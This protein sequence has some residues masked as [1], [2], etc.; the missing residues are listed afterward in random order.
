MEVVTIDFETYYSKEYSL[1]G[2]TTEEY[3]RDPRFEVIGVCIKV[4][5]NP[6]DWYSGSDPG[7]FLNS[8]SYKDKAIL[9][10]NTAFDGAILSWKYGIK[11]K[12]WLDTMS[13]ARPYHA[14][15]CGV[16]LAALAKEYGL[17]E[18]GTEIIAGLDK[19]RTDF[20]PEEL[21]RY[22][23]YC[24]R[25]TEITY[26]L[27]KKLAR[28]TTAAEI[29][30]ID[31][32]IRM[33]TEPAFDLDKDVLSTH[34]QQ[35]QDKKQKLLNA[36]TGGKVSD[37]EL[38]KQL[39]SNELFGSL[40]TKLGV[41]PPRKIS[42]T[43]G[44][45]TWAFSK[46]DKEFLALQEHPHKGVQALV[47]A[48]LGVKSTLEE[49]RTQKFIAVAERGRL[50]IL[51]NYWGAHTGRFSGGDGMNLQNLPR[52]GALRRAL[53]APPGK[54]VATCDSAQIE[55]RLVAW[56]SGQDD[57]V[58]AFREGRD[59]YS[60]FASEV[61]GRPISKQDK[62]ERF[63]GKTCIL[64]LGYGMGPARLQQSLAL[65]A[66][67][68]RV[69]LDD[70]EV[71]R[72]VH[73][74]RTKNHRIEAFWRRCDHVLKDMAA[75][76]SGELIEGAVSYAGNRLILPNNTPLIYPELAMTTDGMSFMDRKT[77]VKIYGGKLTENVV[78]ALA[79]A[80]I[81]DQMVKVGVRHHV[82]LQVHD[83]IVGIINEGQ[84]DVA[85]KFITGI[86]STPPAW[87]S[88]LPLSCEFGV[89]KS[90]GDAK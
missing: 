63:V 30:V 47:S 38:T 27:F 33:F 40:L 28:K 84:E 74:Y 83:E 49:T 29:K 36:L 90:Y 57:L 37:E 80:I 34:L 23:D 22:S 31:Q 14:R 58:Q 42:K 89:G 8:M 81:A 11:P 61:Y 85:R 71:K 87:A 54:L 43:T 35:V 76:N 19:R 18:K 55:A 50:P 72:I 51:L 21:A 77:P 64:G 24:A 62:T 2:L 79:R 56:V 48:R 5:D 3:I 68:I 39:M 66:G 45:E 52:G 73:I 4:D 75:G 53:R 88:D 17:P 65:G 82:P 41:D 67:G 25:D 46:T 9:C 86:M 69:Q 7:G 15:T 12:L 20:S 6:I 60:E 32:T 10:H 70:A 44:K 78:Q 59:V 16:S 1:R 26:K 13:M